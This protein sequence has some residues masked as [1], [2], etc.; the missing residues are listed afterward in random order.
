MPVRI[1]KENNPCYP[2]PANYDELSPAGQRLSRLNALQLQ[3]STDGTPQ[4][5]VY[6][7]SFFRTY[8]LS[9]EKALW[10]KRLKQSPPMHYQIP[11]DMGQYSAN[12]WA[13]PRSFAKSTVCN[14]VA[15]ML[16][17]T[18]PNFSILII[19][20][21][22]AKSRKNMAR[23]KRQLE[24]NPRIVEDFG[25]LKP[26]RGARVWSTEM[27]ELPNGSTIEG[28]S[29]NSALRGDRPDFILID[30][31]EYD[32][33]EEKE[34]RASQLIEDFEKRLF[35]TILGMLDDGAGIFWIGT[36]ISR[37]SFLYHICKGDDPRF[38]SWNRRVL[39][40]IMPDGSLLWE[41]KWDAQAIRDR[42]ARLGETAFNSEM[43]NNP[44]SGSDKTLYIHPELCV[45]RVDGGPERERDPFSSTATLRHRE[46]VRHDDDLDYVDRVESF[47]PWA[48]TLYRVALVD[49]APTISPS[50]DYSC[51][52]ILG[53]DRTDTL[54]V[55]DGF[56]GKIRS[57]ELERKIWDLAFRWKVKLIGVEAVSL[58]KHLADRIAFHFAKMGDTTGFRPKV[59]PV[60]YPG[61]E[62]KGE[63]ICGLEWRFNQYRIKYPVHR[64]NEFW[65]S[66]LFFQTE[67]FTPDLTLLQH[68]DGID[69]VAMHQYVVRRSG[70]S[71]THQVENT[72]KA[73]DFLLQGQLNDEITGVPFITGI[74]LNQLTDD[75]LDVLRKRLHTDEEEAG[76][77]NGQSPVLV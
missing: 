12:A 25:T 14:E 50:S 45:Y 58:Q 27:L 37:K 10:Y 1:P 30:D 18:R 20:A 63:R 9:H 60:K 19:R 4:D 66:Q 68:D 48:K 22:A 33:D 35:K 38:E 16:A 39:S 62:S 7:W 28:S 21:T 49:Y 76:S 46:G 64:K 11:H 55:L 32:E 70:S 41:N 24:E 75:I 31:P 67:N 43:M 3:A 40:V 59:I 47:G 34:G 26:P 6:A 15:M 56:L 13:A 8:Y 5:M 54:W 73:T 42:K 72:K 52:Q 44:G 51:V 29:V 23:I 65:A 2:L 69:T 74:N 53:F 36:L 57:D 17:L 77:W 61:R 71:R